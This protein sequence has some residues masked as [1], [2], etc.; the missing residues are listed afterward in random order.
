M[1]CKNLKIR[2]R[3]GTKFGYCKLKNEEV[4][5][6]CHECSFEVQFKQS[7]STSLKRTSIK[8]KKHKST[9]ASEIPKKVKMTVWKRDDHRCI[10][11]DTPVPW[12]MANSHFIKRSHMGLGI[13]ENIMTNCQSCHEEFEKESKDGWMH[14]KAR[15][16]FREHY[17]DWD[18]KNLIYHK[19]ML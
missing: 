12:N 18:E 10:F 19:N 15:R 9:K 14:R 13:E 11:C 16:H 7:K 4:D 2:T 8:G 3:K 5:L 1:K 6:S 17:D